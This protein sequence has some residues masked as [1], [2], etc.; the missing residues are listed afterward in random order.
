MALVKTSGFL[1]VKKKWVMLTHTHSTAPRQIL[2]IIMQ[3]IFLSP[4]TEINALITAQTVH[5]PLNARKH[6]STGK[7]ET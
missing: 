6:T 1:L 5:N 2:Y 3:I 4:E 7:K